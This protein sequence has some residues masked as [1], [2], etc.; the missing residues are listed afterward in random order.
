VTA[1]LVAL[2]SNATIFL[3]LRRG[4]TKSRRPGPFRGPA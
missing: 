4:R 2:V 1:L 3:L